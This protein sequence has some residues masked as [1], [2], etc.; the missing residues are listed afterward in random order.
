MLPHLQN[1]PGTYQ[2]NLGVRSSGHPQYPVDIFFIKHIMLSM[3]ASFLP[4]NIYKDK[5]KTYN[6]RPVA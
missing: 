3:C 5:T 6:T 1:L 2:S 4:I